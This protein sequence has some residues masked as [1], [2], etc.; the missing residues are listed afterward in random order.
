MKLRHVLSTSAEQIRHG[1]SR[2]NDGTTVRLRCR[3]GCSTS[4]GCVSC[5]ILLH[6]LMG[7]L[8]PRKRAVCECQPCSVL[9]MLEALSLSGSERSRAASCQ[10]SQLP[11]V[12]KA[13]LRN[14]PNRSHFLLRNGPDLRQFLLRCHQLAMPSS[15]IR[16]RGKKRLQS[17]VSINAW[18]S[19]ASASHFARSCS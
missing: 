10:C 4:L 2:S 8:E 1:P 9:D 5:F 3:L 7:L 16:G 15:W 6:R 18:P 12:T 17:V 11:A 14:T 19:S 13:V